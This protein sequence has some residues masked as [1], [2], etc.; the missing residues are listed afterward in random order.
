MTKKLIK[1]GNKSREI[2][3]RAI[4]KSL[5]LMIMNMNRRNQILKDRTQ[6]KKISKLKMKFNLK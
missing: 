5:N 1:I 3:K 6:L 4:W 2:N